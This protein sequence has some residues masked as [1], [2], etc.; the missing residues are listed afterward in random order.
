MNDLVL[1]MGIF[2]IG[3]F[4]S[5]SSQIILKKSALIEY[6]NRVREYLNV[7]VISAYIIFY[8]ATFFG[9]Y[10][11]KVIPLSYGPILESTGYIFVAVLSWIFIKEKISL[12]KGIGIATIIIG[13]IIYSVKW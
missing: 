11:Y 4:I 13:L 9:L 2:L 3:V 5:S 1:Y 12:K 6:P 7:R 8:I 10:A